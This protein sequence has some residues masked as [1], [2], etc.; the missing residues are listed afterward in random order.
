MTGPV[1]VL[2]AQ[3]TPLMPVAPAY[4][5]RLLKQG[6]ARRLPH[7]I[8]T[9]VQLVRTIPAPVLRPIV[10]RSQ[11][12]PAAL[13]LLLLADG[14]RAV[15]PLLRCFIDRTM[16]WADAAALLQPVH[17]ALAALVPISHVVAFPA[18]PLPS[19]LPPALAAMLA[20]GPLHVPRLPTVT[21]TPV[22]GDTSV[23]AQLC[24]QR[25]NQLRSQSTVAEVV[26]RPVPFSSPLVPTHGVVFAWIASTP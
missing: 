21:A 7:H 22:L 24:A 18:D 1:F 17:A 11:A 8:F 19:D 3:H 20:V 2:D 16:P 12:H 6:R 13:E 25:D 15:R 14:T 5:R 23:R 9:V 4:A 10:L 26:P